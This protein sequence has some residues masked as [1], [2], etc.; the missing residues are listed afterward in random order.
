MKG[1]VTVDDDP[2]G[3]YTLAAHTLKINVATMTPA[4]FATVTAYLKRL[5]K[6]SKGVAPSY[7]DCAKRIAD[8]DAVIG[9]P[10]W[11][12]QVGFAAGS[13]NKNVRFMPC[14]RRV[15]TPSATPGPS[16]S[17]MTIP[18]RPTATSTTQSRRKSMRPQPGAGF[19]GGVTVAGAVKYLDKQTRA[20]YDYTT[21]T[22]SSPRRRST[23]TPLS[24]REIRHDRQGHREVAGDQG[25]V[26]TDGR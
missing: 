12:A 7:G 10:G 2:V 4:Q 19:L 11:A 6:Q 20:L 14:P 24:S 16:R 17:R 3:C 15:A 21:S 1:A 8:G 13:G 26:D 9:W 22:T 5:V 23:R 18:T 25:I